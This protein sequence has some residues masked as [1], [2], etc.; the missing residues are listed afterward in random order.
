MRHLLFSRLI[1]GAVA[2]G[3]GPGK[4]TVAQTR[5]AP[6][7]APVETPVVTPIAA[8]PPITAA[9]PAA[10]GGVLEIGDVAAAPGGAAVILFFDVKSQQPYIAKHDGAKV[11]WT[12]AVGG[13]MTSLNL[14]V[15]DDMVA[16]RYQETQALGVERVAAFELATG[17]LR[18]T[19]GVRTIPAQFEPIRGRMLVTPIALGVRTA[20]NEGIVLHRTTGAKLGDLKAVGEWSRLQ[21]VGQDI[22]ERPQNRPIVSVAQ[23]ARMLRSLHKSKDRRLRRL[24]WFGIKRRGMFRGNEVFVIDWRGEHAVVVV[25]RTGK[26]VADIDFPLVVFPYDVEPDE[27]PPELPRF[28]PV[29]YLADLPPHTT[30]G[31]AV[32]VIDLELGTA[33]RVLEAGEATA[34][35]L[36]DGKHWVVVRDRDLLAVDAETGTVTHATMKHAVKGFLETKLRDGSLWLFAQGQH[37]RMIV[38]RV[39]ATTLAPQLGTDLIRPSP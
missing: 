26:I 5:V 6:A 7:A 8:S 16:L 4:P 38:E 33:T 17:Q 37:A 36:R 24:G 15:G 31:D 2:L 23:E 13:N 34:H 20:Q 18:W 29:V 14:A 21:V 28:V 19:T 12:S 35:V 25:T 30:M 11:V 27:V 9:P 22:I 3:C 1:V 32:S 39:D 10:T